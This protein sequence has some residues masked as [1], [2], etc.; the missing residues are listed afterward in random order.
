[1]KWRRRLPKGIVKFKKDND[2]MIRIITITGCFLA[3]IILTLHV[4]P[5]VP[6]LLSLADAGEA[7]NV[8]Y[9][10]EEANWPPFTPNKFGKAEEGLSLALMQAI[11]S[12]LGIEV[13]IELLPMERVLY[14]L[15]EGQKDGATV[16]SRNAERS[17]YLEYSEPLFA[18]RGFVYYRKDRKEPINWNDFADI[19]GLR[20]GIVS[21]HNYGDEFNRAVWRNDL[22][23]ISVSKEKQLFE[24]LM[25]E[26]IDCFLCIDLTAEYY[27][28]EQTYKGKIVPAAKSYFHKDY[29][30]GISKKSKFTAL[31]PKINEVIIRLK[32][33]GSINRLL[34]Q[35]RQD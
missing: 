4:V 27:L 16:I 6:S 28:K 22:K 31:L 5:T 25:A 15:R 34:S 10:A 8:I 32:R 12:K 13:E 3:S 11:F 7:P 1:M 14:Y 24:M 18:K 19:K 17:K 23:T 2:A 9:F 29:H 20:I 35:Y 30:I 33:N 26:R 21:G